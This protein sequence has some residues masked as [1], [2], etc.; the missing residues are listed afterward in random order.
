MHDNGSE[1]TT[2]YLYIA[3][4]GQAAEISITL[5]GTDTPE[6]RAEG[7]S[8]ARAELDAGAVAWAVVTDATVHPAPEIV[9]AAA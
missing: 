7:L 4:R 5:D 2:T 9:A 8:R 3:T 6:L 1:S